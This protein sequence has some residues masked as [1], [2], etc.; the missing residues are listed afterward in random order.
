M[1]ESFDEFFD[2]E[3]ELMDA[4]ETLEGANAASAG[5]PAEESGRDGGS[6]QASEPEHE[7]RTEAGSNRKAASASAAPARQAPPFWMVLAIAGIS[8]VLGV[9]IGYLIGTSATIAELSANTGQSVSASDDAS[10][11]ASLSM[12]EG[13]PE[14]DVD[15]KGNATVVDGSSATGEPDTLSRANTYFDMGMAAMEDA[16]DEAAQ[17][18]AADLFAQAVELYDEYLETTDSPSAE[19]DRAI[20]VFYTGDHDAAIAD[21]EDLV[22]RDASFAPAWAN[23]GMFYESHGDTA[24]AK[25]AYRSAI[26]AAAQ[27]DTYGVKDYAQQRLDAL[28]E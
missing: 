28:N 24:K 18:Q 6:E 25:K 13:H 22:E 8:L 4:G 7:P 20:C 27:D 5:E 23:L 11:E 21:L 3:Q 16:Q 17:Q 14:V 1:S 19:V 9:V 15:E 26:D 10:D 12:P 2:D